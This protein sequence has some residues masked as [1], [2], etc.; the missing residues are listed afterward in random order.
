MRATAVLL[1]GL[2]AGAP[3]VAPDPLPPPLP[4]GSVQ[5]LASRQNV[6]YLVHPGEAI[7][8]PF[9]FLVR[10]FLETEVEIETDS[11]LAVL[12]G[13]PSLDGFCHIASSE[14]IESCWPRCAVRFP[15]SES[16]CLRLLTNGP[17][18]RYHTTRR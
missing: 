13:R 12:V 17:T 7:L 16:R 10:P 5:T 8:E 2:L 14:A 9:D 15:V 6:T 11:P 18:V 4:R 3:R 1:L